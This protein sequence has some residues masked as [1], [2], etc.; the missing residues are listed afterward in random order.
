MG[1]SLVGEIVAAVESG[2]DDLVATSVDR[3]W[4]QVPAYAAN[5][6]PGL[7]ANVM[8]HTRA[9][10]VAVLDTLRAGRPAVREDFPITA[11]QATLRLQAGLELAD[12]L[13]AFR[14]GQVTLWESVVEVARTPRLRDAALE[15]ATHL[16]Q[17]IELGST[18]ASE[19]FLAAQQAELAEGDR[20][21]RDLV[22]DLLAGREP[23]GPRSALALS[24]GLDRATPL[25]VVVAVP[26]APLRPGQ[27][28]RS[29]LGTVRAVI[30]EDRGVAVI[31][32]DQ[33]VALLPATG[34]GSRAVRDLKRVHSQVG[35]QGLRMVVGM[36]TVHPGLSGVPEAYREAVVA[37][38][39]LGGAAG[40]QALSMLSTLDY[41][42]LRDDPTAR[43]LI[44]PEL[45]HFVEEDLAREGVMVRTLMAYVDSDLNAKTAAERLHVHVNTA[46]YRLERIAERT[47][48][49]LRN[50]RE[51]EELVIAVRLLREG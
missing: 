25:V 30:G 20:V 42:V 41:M 14:I 18:V 43:R 16:M 36:S 46:Y 6:D 32:Q 12:F 7:R 44:R 8:T 28:L 40:V 35:R 26:D 23:A 3:F 21:R 15:V 1:T 10:Y 29:A 4:E 51:L 39:S 31:R 38:D 50:F 5:A 19:A 45:R 2:L 33:I 47:G 9:I 37:R 49:D 27:G 13:A 11:E 34:D 48:C 24:C 22:E 17:V